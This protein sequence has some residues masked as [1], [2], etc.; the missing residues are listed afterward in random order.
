MEEVFG[1]AD[2]IGAFA[3]GLIIATSPKG[4]YIQSKFS[5]LSYLL[6]TPVFFANI[7]IKVTL[8]HLDGVVLLFTVL[9]VATA[10][11]S[12]IIVTPITM[13]LNFFVMRFAIEKL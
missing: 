3:A 11:L 9:L 2:I 1:V 7:G 8:P 4:S 5:P 10:I 12:K 6:L 13:T